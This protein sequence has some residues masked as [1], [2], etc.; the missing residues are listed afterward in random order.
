MIIPVLDSYLGRVV[1]PSPL[2]PDRAA[3]LA[4]LADAT[5]SAYFVGML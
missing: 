5:C 4:E 3:R 2:Q 1:F